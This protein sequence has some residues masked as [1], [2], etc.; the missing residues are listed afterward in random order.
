[1]R[2]RTDYSHKTPKAPLFHESWLS[3]EVCHEGGLDP[4]SLGG[5]GKGR[6]IM[7]NRRRVPRQ[8]AGWGGFCHVEGESAAGWRD[9]RVVDI[10]ILGIGIRMQH[11]RPSDLVGRHVSVELPAVG[12]AVNIRFEGEVTNVVR[13][14]LRSARIGIEFVHLSNTER[15][16]LEVLSHASDGDRVLELV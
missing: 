6:C 7:D 16:I 11:S 12:D 3:S 8:T 5:S 13:S 14:T 9:C 15:A 2:Q 4:T 1:V 10:S